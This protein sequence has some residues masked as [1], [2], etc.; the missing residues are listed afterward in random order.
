MRRKLFITLLAAVVVAAVVMV[1]AASGGGT[2]N[3]K[4]PPIQAIQNANPNAPGISTAPALQ[5]VSPA[6]VI[7]AAQQPGADVEGTPPVVGNPKTSVALSA[8][9][10]EGGGGSVCWRWLPGLTWGTWP[11][12]N[13]MTENRYWCA[14]YVGG[15]ITYRVSHVYPMYGINSY[16]W[17]T[18][19]AY[20]FRYSGGV[21]YSWVTVQVGANFACPSWPFY[22]PATHWSRWF[23]YA[24]NVWGSGSL[25][26]HS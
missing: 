4:L 12:E 15:W 13:G 2:G 20:A 11:L 6:E 9:D 3:G 1:S 8:D 23:R 7:Q 16:C 19:G 21:G 10:A 5:R 24:S 17:Y 22:L 25:V 14:S 26:D 18:D